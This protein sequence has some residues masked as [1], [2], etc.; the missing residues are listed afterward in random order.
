MLAILTVVLTSAIVG[1]ST[2]AISNKKSAD[3]KTEL[4]NQIETLKSEVSQAEA[5]DVIA[6]T[7]PTPTPT[8]TPTPGVTSSPAVASGTY[9]NKKFGFAMKVPAKWYVNQSGTCEG[10]CGVTLKFSIEDSSVASTL[11][12]L[13][14]TVSALD[15]K[16]L[17]A[18]TIDGIIAGSYEGS[19]YDIKSSKLGA[20]TAKSF[21]RGLSWSLSFFSPRLAASYRIF[22]GLAMFEACDLH[23]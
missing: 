1:T 6:S 21:N 19:S 22:A 3:E 7:T 16:D 11:H 2:Y 15:H 17:E 5:E 13:P 9:E 8:L 20:L 10:L 12:S 4:Q 14:L 18:P 23:R